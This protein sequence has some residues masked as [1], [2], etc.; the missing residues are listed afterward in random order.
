VG[1]SGVFNPTP[2]PPQ[3]S[4]IFTFLCEIAAHA[5]PGGCNGIAVSPLN[6]EPSLRAL[7]GRAGGWFG[8]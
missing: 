1:F 4:I 2:P 7:D 6:C 3:R 5:T 8:G